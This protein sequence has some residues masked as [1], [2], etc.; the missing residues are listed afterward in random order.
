MA[1][2]RIVS[3]LT[4]LAV[5]GCFAWNPWV[6]E[7]PLPD[8][9]TLEASRARTLRPGE[10]PLGGALDCKGGRCQQWFRIDLAE[11]GALRIEARIDGLVEPARARL[12]LQDGLGTT[13]GSA[14]SSEGLP[15]VV[16]SPV[17]N[18]PHAVLLQVGGGPVAFHIEASFVP[19][20]A[21]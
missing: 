9:A 18:G 12:F 10:P 3:A 16:E 5:S 20:A 21:D 6:P 14:R 19:G 1:V 4:L 8:P 7:D 13:L 2:L 15:L 17:V 11:P